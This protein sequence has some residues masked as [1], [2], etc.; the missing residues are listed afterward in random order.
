M[1][2]VNKLYF[3]FRHWFAQHL[4]K[5]Y[6]LCDNHKAVLKFFIAGG[7][8]SLTD[9]V[10]L[11]VFH[12]WFRWGLVL[13]TSLAFILSFIVSFSLQKFW[14]FRNY[15]RAMAIRQFLLYVINAVVGLNL[16]GLGMHLLV[17]KYKIWYMFSQVVVIVLIGFYNFI[18]YR[19]II[20]RSSSHENNC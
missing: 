5:I 20:F 1:P 8:A 9:L 7:L 3:K 15:D 12:G 18:I 10:L 14:T 13:S 19:F 16:N 2:F 11:Y 4:P 17:N 6:C